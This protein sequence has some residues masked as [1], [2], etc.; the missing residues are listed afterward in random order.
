MTMSTMLTSK[1]D[2]KYYKSRYDMLVSGQLKFSY[3]WGGQYYFNEKGAL[4]LYSFMS[5]DLI[6]FTDRGSI[7]LADVIYIHYGLFLYFDPY[8][9]HWHK[10]YMKWFKANKEEFDRLNVD[11]LNNILNK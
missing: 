8:A 11:K 3:A 10:K 4:T 7:K 1:Q 6:F 9:F 5:N 2:Y